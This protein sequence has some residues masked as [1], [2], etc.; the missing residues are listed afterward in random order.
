MTSLQVTHPKSMRKQ[1]QLV[2]TFVQVYLQTTFC[3][4]FTKI[5]SLQWDL[6]GLVRIS[7]SPVATF[8]IRWLSTRASLNL[9]RTVSSDLQVHSP[10]QITQKAF[11]TKR[12]SKI[13][14][15]LKFFISTLWSFMYSLRAQ[16]PN[17]KFKCCSFYLWHVTIQH[18]GQP[19]ELCTNPCLIHQR[20]GMMY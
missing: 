6:G 10:Y 19:L 15:N 4:K 9:S 7:R 14:F 8:L 3:I 17:L 18:F 20:N 1:R 11:I 12:T 16:N 2:D 5:S 13:D